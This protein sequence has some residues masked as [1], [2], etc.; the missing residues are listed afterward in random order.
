MGVGQ[1]ANCNDYS[2][3]QPACCSHSFVNNGLTESPEEGIQWKPLHRDRLISFF[4]LCL[5][6]TSGKL[7]REAA[8]MFNGVM[9]TGI[10]RLVL[11]D[12]RAR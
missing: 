11:H 5:S 3:Q 10:D 1:G 2:A 9:V 6:D 4:L 7:L 8:R 12:R